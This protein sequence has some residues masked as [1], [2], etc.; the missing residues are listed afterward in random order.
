[1]TD[2]EWAQQ[3]TEASV[4][5]V[6]SKGEH[7]PVWKEMA[8]LAQGLIVCHLETLPQL[9]ALTRFLVAH[10]P[11]TDY[12][13]ASTAHYLYRDYTWYVMRSSDAIV[14]VAL[15]K[16]DKTTLHV[17]VF[18][19]NPAHAATLL[20]A[21]RSPTCRSVT[22]F[23]NNRECVQSMAA[24]L[25][26]LDP[27]AIMAAEQA[28]APTALAGFEFQWSHPCQLYVLAA[29][30]RIP[31]HAV[32]ELV[33]EGIILDWVRDSDAV[34]IDSLWPYRSAKS[35]GT[36]ST[37]I[38]S[39]PCVC[40]RTVADGRPVCWMVTYHYGSIGMLHTV[41]SHRRQGLARA[42]VLA[43]CNHLRIVRSYMP[44]FCHI[45]DDNA[46]SRSLFESMGFVRRGTA[47]WC[48]YRI[49]L[50]GEPKASVDG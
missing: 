12:L 3:M 26:Q 46:P 23:A 7:D 50:P 21:I 44:P 32:G 4:Q 38:R 34:L 33:H 5:S 45:I 1:M 17:S 42:V 13:L 28:A 31:E 20:G 37:I 30:T 27:K 24:E 43:L 10:A 8:R 40:A 18:A 16:A 35:L 39:L 29:T 11:S 22:F 9:Q 36:I 15:G 14:A 41:D 48:E 2:E 6:V 49:P 47:D 19:P 25:T